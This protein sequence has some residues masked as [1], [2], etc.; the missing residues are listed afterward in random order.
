[1]KADQMFSESDSCS[2]M[3]ALQMFSESA[4]FVQLYESCPNVLPPFI[5]INDKMFDVSHMYK[6]QPWFSGHPN[7]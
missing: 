7:A 6:A 3:K 2:F 1:M 4:E 5:W